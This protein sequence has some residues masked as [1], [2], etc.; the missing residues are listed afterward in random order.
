MPFLHQAVIFLAAAVVAVPL[1]QRFGLGS[2]LGYLAAGAVIGPWGL[3]AILEVEGTMHFAEL[4]VVLFLFIIGLELQ[5][6]RLW[7]M[8]RTVFGFGFAQM[9]FSTALLCGAAM[10]M[11]VAGPSA[12]IIGAGLS[13]SSTAFALQL[14]SEKNQLAC[15]FGQAAFGILL[16]QDLAVI[17]LLAILPLF[18]ATAG[19]EHALPLW[20]S[21]L[22]VVAVLVAVFAGGRYVLR[23]IFKQIAAVRSQEMMTAAALLVVVG[24]ALLVSAVGLSMSLGAFLAGVLLAES[25]YRHELEAD[26]EPFK[27]LLLGLFFMAVGMSVNLRLLLDQPFLVLALVFGLLLVKGLILFGLGL[28]CFKSLEEALR[29]GVV[30]CQ[31]GEFAFVLFGVATRQELLSP[32]IADLLVVV[33][34]LSMALTP[35]LYAGLERLILPRL[36][37]TAPREFDVVPFNDNP[38]IIV[39]FGRVGQM[40]ARVLRA[41]RIGFTA[42]DSNPEHIDFVRRFGSKVFYGDASRLDLLRAAGVER[43]RVFVLAVQNVDASVRIAAVVREHFPNLTIFARARN[44]PHVYKLLGLGVDKFFRDTFPA[45]LEMTQAVLQALGLP[46]SESRHAIER[47]REHDEALLLEASP[48]QA[49]QSKL[50]EIAVRGREQLERLFDQDEQNLDQRSA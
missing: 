11:G 46:Y 44:R 28:R 23:P 10:L 37:R 33:V 47:F 34:T 26:I 45:S 50:A 30:I 22:R 48:H 18:G 5:P 2:V 19:P 6:S 7:A 20:A 8:R 9:V 40:V 49:D 1:F 4:G 12:A 35:L 21:L 16:F 42:L 13:L 41:K 39:G 3:G 24:T 14:L 31:G 27:G 25:E 38:V 17:P 36:E 43:A 15:E 29:L 32:E